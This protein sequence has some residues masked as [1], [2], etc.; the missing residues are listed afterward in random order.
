MK[1]LQKT[2]TI[3]SETTNIRLVEDFILETCEEM[4]LNDD[5][6]NGLMIAVTEAANN[7]ILHG[8]HSDSH[9]KVSVSMNLQGHEL[10]VSVTDE[11]KGFDPHSLPD[12]LAEENILKTNGRGVFL[13]KNI[14]RSVHYLF[15]P[16]GTT[17]IMHFD[18]QGV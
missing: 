17:V 4:G 15:N 2:I 13:M 14:M 3:T 7:G 10:I 16:E 12:P 11:G 5:E 9:K 1:N 8:N 18:V 6:I